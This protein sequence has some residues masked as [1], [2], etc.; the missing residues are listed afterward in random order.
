MITLDQLRQK[1][2]TALQADARFKATEPNTCPAPFWLRDVILEGTAP[3]AI[4]I[5]DGKNQR[6]LKLPVNVDAEG[7]VTLSAEEPKIADMAYIVRSRAATA[8]FSAGVAPA[9]FMWMPGGISTVR[10]SF[11]GVIRG[12]R[13]DDFPCEE[14]VECEPTAVER[15]NKW[16]GMMRAEMPKRQPYGCFE[17]NR[18]NASMHPRD[19]DPFDWDAEEN[20]IFVNGAWSGGGQ[21]A[22]KEGEYFGWS[23]SYGTDAAWQRAVEKGGR[24]VFPAD[25]R[26]GKNNPS[27]VVA[28]GFD[29]GGLTNE[30]AFENISQVRAKRTDAEK[31]NGGPTATTTGAV[32]MKMK[33]YFVRARGGHAAGTETELSGD[34]LTQALES[35]DAIP[36][37][38]APTV[39]AS[40]TAV[41]TEKENSKKLRKQV[42][43]AAITR[44]KS[45]EAFPP[46]RE[47][48]VRAK[49]ERLAAVD[50]ETAV[51]YLDD[52]Q[53]TNGG[54]TVR[55][56]QTEGSTIEVGHPGL[57]EAFSGIVR[58]R[59]PMNG[60]IRANRMAEAHNEAVR[61]SAI[62]AEVMT[63]IRGGGD[64]AIPDLVRAGTTDA[65]DT[66]AGTLAGL[67]MIMRD[68]GFLENE[69]AILDD[70]TTDF[71]NEPIKFNNW[72]SSRF[73]SV[74]T[75]DSWSGTAWTAGTANANTA[76]DLKVKMDKLYRVWHSAHMTLLGSTVRNLLLEQ[77]A[78]G[79]QGLAE[80][81]FADIVSVMM[82]GKNDDTGT[83]VNFT[84]LPAGA[85][86]YKAGAFLKAIADFKASE[87][88]GDLAACL[89]LQKVPDMEGWRFALLHSLAYRRMGQ[90]TAFLTAEAIANAAKGVASDTM[91]TG[92]LPR[93]S[94]IQFSKSQLSLD[95]ATLAASTGIGFC[96]AKNSVVFCAR[97]PGDWTTAFG[98][99]VPNTAATEIV[100]SP[101]LKMPFFYVRYLDNPNE[102]ANA[103]GYA[104]GGVAVGQK[105]SGF[106]IVQK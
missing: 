9:R 74:A 93:L 3:V 31:P 63:A 43:D 24:L 45:R 20:G 16:Y 88:P 96:G 90:D 39:R 33:V 75:P 80:K 65:T 42:L 5:E 52:L 13:Y 36:A 56:R 21:R 76:T 49:A 83:L 23:P 7:N 60:L 51:E 81:F 91:G 55:A 11:T 69:L 100:V 47:N 105:G 85:P 35:G 50:V 106:R 62:W 99:E 95:A 37:A 29:I 57:R 64:I 97:V 101:R 26:G 34:E 17:H 70:I 40:Q 87:T 53:A 86:G 54:S 104:M 78:P 38:A 103:R 19:T 94:N 61:A 46:A 48:D 41:E 102:T 71:S 84:G 98:T 30:P 2:W 82:N 12:Q 8:R 67:V 92:R 18:T 68:L 79:L 22:V 4:I 27:R 32:P 59:K 6:L 28:V 1:F 44:A 89:D 15:L 58:A 25:A 77:K 73:F 72:A 10:A 14:H 66:D